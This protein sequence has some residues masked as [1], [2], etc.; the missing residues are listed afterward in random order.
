MEI[1]GFPDLDQQSSGLRSFEV[2]N[3]ASNQNLETILLIL[4]IPFISLF[5]TW[6]IFY[7][8]KIWGLPVVNFCSILRLGLLFLI[9]WLQVLYVFYCNKSFICFFTIHNIQFIFC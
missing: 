5:K 4:Q 7:N 3:Q 2:N 8:L 1:G 9:I 6:A